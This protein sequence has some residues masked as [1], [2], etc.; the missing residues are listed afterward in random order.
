M[1]YFVRHGA[2]D[3]NENKNA[4]GEK[5]PRFQGR[6]DIP[7]NNKGIEQAQI[8]A[9]QLKGIKFDR[10]ICS[11]LNRAIQTCNLIYHGQTPVEI[12]ERVIER[13]F[14]EFE[15]MTMSEFDFDVF[16][17]RN[18][19]QKW[20]KAESIQEV[21]KRVFNLLDELK[22]KPEQNVL[23]VSH[24]GVGC[25]LISYFMGIPESGDYTSFLLPHGKPLVLDFKT[26][27]KV[28]QNDLGKL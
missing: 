21:E 8:M 26:I 27:D 20:Q 2:T 11:P 6:A 15:G 12:D 19:Q 3:W 23:I 1:I 4:N 16:C 14:G 28:K 5:A 25:V 13:D 18:T 9:Q 7:L 24:G 17:N 10:V 22:K